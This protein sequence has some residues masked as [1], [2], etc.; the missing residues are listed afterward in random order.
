M[1]LIDGAYNPVEL[2]IYN[3]ESEYNKNEWGPKWM[4]GARKYGASPD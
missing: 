1:S 3:S 2:F 4:E